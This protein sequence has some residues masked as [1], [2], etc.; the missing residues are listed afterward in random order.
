MMDIT[1]FTQAAKDLAPLF[2]PL[3]P[4]LLKGVKL[5]G[6]EFVKSIGAKTG[7]KI[8]EVLEEMWAKVE[9]KINET[10]GAQQIV[11]TLSENQEDKEAR[12]AFERVLEGVLHDETLRREIIPLLQKAKDSGVTIESVI[13]ISKLYGDVR[14][15]EI[16]NQRLPSKKIR[17]EIDVETANP[18]STITGVSLTGTTLRGSRKKTN[19]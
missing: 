6:K 1:D 14:G 18:G 16:K 10:P 4:Y 17:S 9:P 2:V 8:P 11:K 3:L 12:N 19:K 15:V 5:A 13:K 7:E